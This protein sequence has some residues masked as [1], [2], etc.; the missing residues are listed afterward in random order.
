MH[1]SQRRHEELMLPLSLV[2][3]AEVLSSLSIMIG[4]VE[5]GLLAQGK[6]KTNIERSFAL[7]PAS[8]II[9]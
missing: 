3:S 1:F 6:A 4:W 2:T 8:L 7:T 9:S 5:G